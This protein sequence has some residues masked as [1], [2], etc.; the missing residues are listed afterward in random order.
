MPARVRQALAYDGHH[1]LDL[2]GVARVI[3]A[4]HAVR[5]ARATPEV[6][7]DH[8]PAP[9]PEVL[10]N[11]L[12]VVT[13]AAAFQAMKQ[14]QCRGVGRL[15]QTGPVALSDPAPCAGGCQARVGLYAFA[16]RQAVS[17]QAGAAPVKIDEIAIG[18]V[19]PLT[20]ER[21]DMVPRHE[22]TVQGLQV[23]AGQP[24]RSGAGRSVDRCC[25]NGDQCSVWAGSEGSN[26]G[27]CIG[28]CDA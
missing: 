11:G 14:D 19:D 7:N 20:H 6:G 3:G 1:E 8:N 25:H 4:R 28:A 15:W 10:R 18:C 5:K 26:R 12:R 2:G 17:E 23:A 16:R 27:S 22:C 13:L 9:C 24:A 21:N